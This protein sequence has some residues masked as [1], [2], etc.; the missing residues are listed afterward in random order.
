MA[1]GIYWGGGTSRKVKR[2]YLGI[3]GSSRKVKKDTSA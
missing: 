2:V 3:N 1:K